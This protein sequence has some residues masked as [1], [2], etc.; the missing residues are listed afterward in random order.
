MNLTARGGV[1]E[2]ADGR[3]R[4]RPGAAKDAAGVE[5][6]PRRAARG[7]GV[8]RRAAGGARCRGVRRGR[9]LSRRAASSAAWRSAATARN[10][11]D[12]KFCQCL[13]CI[14][15]S[16]ARDDLGEGEGAEVIRGRG[17]RSRAVASPG[18]YDSLVP[19]DATARY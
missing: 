6:G 10:G 3:W 18:T 11:G 1:D 15:L 19:G 16:S 17:H 8:W 5:G 4:P 2:A 7:G 13:P 9:G 14:L 12:G